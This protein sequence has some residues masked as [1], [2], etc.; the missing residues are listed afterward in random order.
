MSTMGKSV[1][2]SYITCIEKYFLP[3]FQDKRLEEI[4]YTDVHE[5]EV[6]RN[7]QMNKVPRA[8]T[9][10]NFA[11][12]WTKLQLVAI[13]KGWISERVA[14]P[15]L[16][17][18]GQK[19][20]TRPAFTREEI[21]RLLEFMEPWIKQGRLEIEHET[22]PLLRDYIEMLLYTGMRHGTEALG[23]RWKNT[24]DISTLTLETII[25]PLRD[26]DTESNL[27]STFNVVQEK[28]IR[29]GFVKQQGRNVR[30]VKP[31]TSLNMDTMINQKLW[32]LAETFI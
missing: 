23:I 21:D 22:R 31:I 17:A 28:L 18:R 19:G 11:S 3:Y 29:G 13:S 7:R 9:L 20:K 6:W 27:W 16:T 26:G 14:I 15:K 8:S 32:E 30:T 25:N 5:F 24:E 2:G 4:T 12:A 1:Y 10:N